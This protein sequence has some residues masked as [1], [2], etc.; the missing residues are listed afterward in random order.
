MSAPSDSPLVANWGRYK[1]QPRR[2]LPGWCWL[3]V[4]TAIVGLSAVGIWFASRSHPW[5]PPSGAPAFRSC[6]YGGYVNGWCARVRVP[7]DPRRPAGPTIAL[8]VTVLPATTRP[9]EGA[10][11]YLEGGP[12]GAA[13]ASAIRVNA[14]F[15]GVGRRRD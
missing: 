6:T 15:A 5:R 4:A 11:F 7:E 9:A 12:G 13:T 8:H 2:S 1:R 3:M 10:L 14:M